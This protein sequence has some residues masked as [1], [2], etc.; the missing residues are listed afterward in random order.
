MEELIHEIGIRRA[1]RAIGGP[2]IPDDV[3]QLR[4]FAVRAS[5]KASASDSIV[6]A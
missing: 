1:K 4:L 5:P 6:A 3:L 2:K